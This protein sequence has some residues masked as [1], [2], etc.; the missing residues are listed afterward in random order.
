MSEPGERVLGR[1][2]AEVARI[3]QRTLSDINLFYRGEGPEVPKDEWTSEEEEE[4]EGE[5]GD[6]QYYRASRRLDYIHRRR[7]QVEHDQSEPDANTIRLPEFFFRDREGRGFQP[8][9]EWMY[10]GRNSGIH[11]VHGVDIASGGPRMYLVGSRIFIVDRTTA[12]ERHPCID[13]LRC[14]QSVESGCPV[15]AYKFTGVIF[16]KGQH[17]HE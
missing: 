10:V 14:E 6:F 13:L 12:G 1:C 16:I 7:Q 11:V 5:D 4:E 8:H 3:V 17:N 15:Y 9:T 2:N